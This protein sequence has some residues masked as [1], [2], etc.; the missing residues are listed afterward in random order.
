[1]TDPDWNDHL[2]RA[3][4]A[5]SFSFRPPL[6][7]LAAGALRLAWTTAEAVHVPDPI[8]DDYWKIQ[9]DGIRESAA[10]LDGYLSPPGVQ[11]GTGARPSGPL[12]DTPELRESVAD[13]LDAGYVAHV[14]HGAAPYTLQIRQDI[15]YALTAASLELGRPAPVVDDGYDRAVLFTAQDVRRLLGPDRP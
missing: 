1:V 7:D 14:S 4:V 15:T 9:R 2:R 11:L 10:Y 5:I 13:L 8:D 3:A 12:K 6:N